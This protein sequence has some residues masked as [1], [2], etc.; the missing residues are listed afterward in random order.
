KVN[1]VFHGGVEDGLQDF[2]GGT[3]FRYLL[4]L[5]GSVYKIS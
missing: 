5:T 2:H 4:T 1:A 3:S